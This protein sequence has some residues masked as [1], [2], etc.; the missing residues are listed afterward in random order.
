MFNLGA[1]SSFGSFKALD[2]LERSDKGIIGHIRSFRYGSEELLHARLL[3][4]FSEVDDVEVGASSA[5]ET[6]RSEM[7]LKRQEYTISRLL[8]CQ[9][10]IGDTAIYVESILIKSRCTRETQSGKYSSK[11]FLEAHG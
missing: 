4:R 3:C 9:L 8:H 2:E 11:R 5:D 10:L 6:L 1:T 7:V